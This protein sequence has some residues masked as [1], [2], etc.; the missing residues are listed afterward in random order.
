MRRIRPQAGVAGVVAAGAVGYGVAVTT[1][2]RA[3]TW[4][5][6]AAWATVAVAVV[7]AFYARR[8]VRLA[9]DD[10]RERVRPF[11]TVDLVPEE[12]NGGWWLLVRNAGVTVARDVRL[13]LDPSSWEVT[14][15]ADELLQ[16]FLTRS[17]PTMPPGR[18]LR[19]VFTDPQH[20]SAMPRTFT[21][22]V[23]CRDYRGVEQ[24]PE[25]YVLDLDLIADMQYIEP[26]NV[27]LARSLQQIEQMLKQVTDQRRIRVLAM[28]PADVA[29]QQAEEAER[30]RER[31]A[32]HER[33]REKLTPPADE[34]DA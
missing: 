16:R 15:R 14:D 28:S 23:R 19:T 3:E 18:E 12:E 6:S 33:L 5:A 21:V 22:T 25:D 24:P 2:V 31:R 26:P 29:R 30:L 34:T 20:Q 7:A 13:T 4:A 27:K 11:V 1:H 8:Q 32:H 17:I 9:A 10:R